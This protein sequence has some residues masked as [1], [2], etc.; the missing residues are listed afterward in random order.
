[1]LQQPNHNQLLK[2]LRNLLRQHQRKAAAMPAAKA[3]NEH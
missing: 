2:L 1:L 3:A